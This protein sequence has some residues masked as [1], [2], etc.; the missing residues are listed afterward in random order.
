MAVKIIDAT[1]EGTDFNRYQF[2]L[3]VDFGF[4]HRLWVFSGRRGIHC[5]VSDE[6]ACKL[7]NQGRKALLSYFERKC[8]ELKKKSPQPDSHPFSQYFVSHLLNNFMYPLPL[9]D[10]TR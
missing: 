10:V 9:E 4:K 8:G 3:I 7:S 1:L 2:S 6:N 5:W